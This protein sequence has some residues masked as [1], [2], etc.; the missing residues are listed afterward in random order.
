MFFFFYSIYCIHFLV[1][2][3]W[4]IEGRGH[5]RWSLRLSGFLAK[6]SI[7]QDQ[8]ILVKVY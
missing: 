2:W 6:A 5:W 8:A 4:G 3:H 1:E 7:K